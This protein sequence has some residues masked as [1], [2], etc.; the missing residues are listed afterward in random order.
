MSIYRVTEVIGTSPTSW[1]EAAREAL[2]AAS[3]TLRD[4]RVA[5]VAEQ[6]IVID[7]RGGIQQFRVKL[8]VSFKYEV[9]WNAAT[10]HAGAGAQPHA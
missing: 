10:A 4:L 3:L 9:P 7:D 5:E 1:E 8:K 6:D 2:T